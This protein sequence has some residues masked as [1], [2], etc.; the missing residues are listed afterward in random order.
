MPYFHHD[1]MEK[2]GKKGFLTISIPRASPSSL[3]TRS[4]P[5]PSSS[6]RLNAKSPTCY[7][8]HQSQPKTPLAWTWTC[9]CCQRIWSMGTTQRCLHCSHRMC[10]AQEEEDEKK[11]K[12]KNK[13]RSVILAGHVGRK[14]VFKAEN[15]KDYKRQRLL[16]HRTMMRK[17]KAKRKVGRPCRT[18][19]DYH[20]WEGW[21][22][23]R[24]NVKRSNDERHDTGG[25]TDNDDAATIPDSEDDDKTCENGDNEEKKQN[26]TL[27]PAQGRLHIVGG[28]DPPPQH[29]KV[30]NCWDDCDYPSQC[31]YGN[32][33]LSPILE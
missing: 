26:T 23:W 31:L 6:A 21:N 24:R 10:T 1:D 8:R 5:L 4:S 7:R 28:N 20:G 17:R 15:D 27:L 3:S 11:E 2:R 14:G 25:D 9:H 30:H 19:F 18:H 22:Q 12:N 13:K 33:P 32:E 29:D 16:S